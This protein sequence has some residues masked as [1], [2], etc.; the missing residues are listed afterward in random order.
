MAFRKA[1]TS[2]MLK[3]AH[4]TS[5]TTLLVNIIISIC[6]RRMGMFWKNFMRS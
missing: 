1:M 6:L 3:A 2:N 4:A 5:S